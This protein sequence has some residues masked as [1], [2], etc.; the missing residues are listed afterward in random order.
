MLALVPPAEDR[1]APYGVRG[2]GTLRFYLQGHARLKTATTVGAGDDG[3][4]PTS[5]WRAAPEPDAAVARAE[6]AAAELKLHQ[7]GAEGSGWRRRRPRRARRCVS[8][9]RAPS[10]IER[11]VPFSSSRRSRPTRSPPTST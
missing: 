2:A 3:R 9:A 8:T 6:L 7:L 11:W 10:R 1:G 5:R 4:T